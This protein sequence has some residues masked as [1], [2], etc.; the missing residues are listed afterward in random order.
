MRAPKTPPD[1]QR[2][3]DAL[4]LASDRD[5]VRL[6]VAIDRLLLD[7]ERIAAIRG[8]L[9]IGQLISYLSERQNRVNS[10]RIVELMADRV[11][12]QTQDH[13][14][15]WLHYASIQVDA[16]APQG[17]AASAPNGAE[18]SVGDMVSFDDR[19]QVHRFGLVRRVNPK[20]VTVQIEGRQLRVPHGSLRRVV[21]I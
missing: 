8:K 19:D 1:W 21:D 6:R 14:L 3:L 7:P 2:F 10:G 15:R 17:A 16:P 11:L 18:F 5:L 13:M 4:H 20:T 12:I 9:V